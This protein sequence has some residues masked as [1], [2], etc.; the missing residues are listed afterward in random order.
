[1]ATANARTDDACL[2]KCA[3][4][5]FNKA[6][7][8]LDHTDR[9]AEA[10]DAMLAAAFAQRHLRGRVGGP[11][12]IERAEWQVSRVCAVLGDRGRL[13]DHRA[14]AIAACAA[15]AEKGDREYTESQIATIPR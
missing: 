1:M 11:L 9:D 8:Y 15:I 6:W 14:R 7:E 13:E 3:A 4:E 5:A 10:D 12:E 2:K